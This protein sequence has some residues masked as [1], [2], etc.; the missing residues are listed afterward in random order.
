MSTRIGQPEPCA[1][2]RSRVSRSS[3]FCF[4][5]LADRITLD[6]AGHAVTGRGR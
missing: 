6:L 2:L 5:V 3:G 4:S 1:D